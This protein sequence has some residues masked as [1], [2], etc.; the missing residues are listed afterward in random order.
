MPW[1]KGYARI[2]L[3]FNWTVTVRLIHE[4]FLQKL[5]GNAEH[6]SLQIRIRMKG[7]CLRALP[8]Q[9]SA[10]STCK[11]LD[12]IRVCSPRPNS[13]IRPSCLM[14]VWATSRYEIGT[15][16]VCRNLRFTMVWIAATILNATNS[17][18]VH[19]LTHTTDWYLHIRFHYTN[20]VGHRVWNYRRTEAHGRSTS[21]FLLE[22]RVLVSTN[23]SSETTLC[24]PI[25]CLSGRVA[26]IRRWYCRSRTTGNG[27]DYI[28]RWMRIYLINVRQCQQRTG[29]SGSHSTQS[30]V[31]P[32][33]VMNEHALCCRHRKRRRTSLEDRPSWFLHAA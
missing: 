20:W 14:M 17:L 8:M 16:D 32:A 7:V 25:G 5:P 24:I 27:L 10:R 23:K 30:S 6:D 21:K 2:D 11:P 29:E 19:A 22:M 13:P 31:P 3:C 15:S 26:T 1:L 9:M 33:K 18:N 28:D 12:K 4:F